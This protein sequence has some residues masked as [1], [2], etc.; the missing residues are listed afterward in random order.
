MLIICSSV[1]YIVCTNIIYVGLIYINSTSIILV[2]R[3][4]TLSISLQDIYM[5]FTLKYVNLK[6]DLYKVLFSYFE[7]ANSLVFIILTIFLKNIQYIQYYIRRF[8]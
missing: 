8:S 3:N 6:F 2:T 1:R 4:K 5:F 7:N